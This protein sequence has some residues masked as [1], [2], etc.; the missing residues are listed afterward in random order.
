MIATKLQVLTA[1][2]TWIIA[3][4]GGVVE[5]PQHFGRIRPV[6]RPNSRLDHRSKQRAIPSLLSSMLWITWPQV[7]LKRA[8]G[9]G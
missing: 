6:L 1:S 3:G 2:G 9:L 8:M 5:D 4:P 7:H